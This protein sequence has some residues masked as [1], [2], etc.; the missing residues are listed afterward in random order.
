MTYSMTAFV[1]AKISTTSAIYGCEIR[2]V[3]HR[4][5]DVHFRLPEKLK[6]HEASLKEIITTTLNRGRVDCYIK[7][8]QLDDQA[9]SVELDKVGA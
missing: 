5:L 8:E 3:N 7:K 4:F 2:C 1:S 9:L 6:K